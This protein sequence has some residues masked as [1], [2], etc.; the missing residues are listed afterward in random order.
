MQL[1][2]IRDALHADKDALRDVTLAANQ[3]YTSTMP[4]LHWRLYLQNILAT[5][6]E[7]YPTDQVVVEQTGILQ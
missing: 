6:S 3:Q 7:V 2:H 4:P 1:F 5:L